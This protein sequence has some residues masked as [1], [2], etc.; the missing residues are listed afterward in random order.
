[1][2]FSR[3][4]IGGE[5]FTVADLG[6]NGKS[7]KAVDFAKELYFPDDQVVV[8]PATIGVTGEIHQKKGSRYENSFGQLIRPKDTEQDDQSDAQSFQTGMGYSRRSSLR[9]FFAQPTKT[10]RHGAGEAGGKLK[11]RLE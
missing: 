8:F 2:Y 7:D 6:D 3:N 9:N 5:L 4:F 11:T 10:P 1:M